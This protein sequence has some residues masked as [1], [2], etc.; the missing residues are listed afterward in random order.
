MMKV[1]LYRRGR[2]SKE[3]G[4]KERAGV[5]FTLIPLILQVTWVMEEGVAGVMLEDL[6][7]DDWAG[8]CGGIRYPLLNA[9]THALTINK[10]Y[11]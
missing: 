4:G 8:F 1:I 9:A 10:E 3:I 2:P 7:S 5:V 11:L 6:N